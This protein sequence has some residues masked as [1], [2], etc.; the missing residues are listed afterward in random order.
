MEGILS[1]TFSQQTG[2]KP[3]F[4]KAFGKFSSGLRELS[5]SFASDPCFYFQLICAL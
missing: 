3:H 2:Y 4:A 5:S 1:I